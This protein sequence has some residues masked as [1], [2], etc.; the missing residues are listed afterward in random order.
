MNSISPILNLMIKSCEKVSKVLIRDFGEVEKLQVSVKGPKNFVT[1]SDK[2]VE[3]MLVKELSKSKKNYSF[4]TEESGF[5]KNKDTE[6][7]WVIDPIDGTTNF[8]NGVPHFCISVGLVLDNEIVSGVIYDPIKDEI[9]YAEKN[10]GAYMNNKSIRVSR[11]RQ[12][13]ECLFSSNSNKI[14]SDGLSIRITGSAA[15]DLAYVA[16]GR[17]DGFFHNKINIWDVAAG[18]LL[19]QEA[20]G[21]VNDI[22][23]FK[24]NN[25]DI[26]ASSE[27]INHKMLKN[28]EKF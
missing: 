8:I 10:S 22:N 17:L 16:S 3:D 24:A 7:F 28:L 21:I 26:R 20:G 13:S 14:S 11:K 23:K 25:I 6:N 5:I 19:V 1:N 9:Y 27:A 18:V 12:I 4:L 2:K 15:L